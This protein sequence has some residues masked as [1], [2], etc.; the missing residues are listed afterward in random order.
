MVTLFLGLFHQVV[1]CIKIDDKH[2]DLVFYVTLNHVEIN[3][4][5]VEQ[6]YSRLDTNYISSYIRGIKVHSAIRGETA[7]IL[8]LNI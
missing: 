7:C 1:D 5:I 6:I 4:E 8:S 2:C 3:P